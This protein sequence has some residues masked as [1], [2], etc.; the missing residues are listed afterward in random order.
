M[1]HNRYDV[2]E[3]L[4]KPLRIFLKIS[5]EESSLLELDDLNNSDFININDNNSDL[6]GSDVTQSDHYLT[7]IQQLSQQKSRQRFS[8][9]SLTAS[10]VQADENSS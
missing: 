6:M 1:T 3:D 5:P 7:S 2:K 10:L 8:I 4:I 9:K